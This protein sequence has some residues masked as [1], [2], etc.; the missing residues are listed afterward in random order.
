MREK[1]ELRFNA[2]TA[3]LRPALLAIAAFAACSIAA[4]AR[5]RG[6]SMVRHEAPR[7]LAQATQA[8]AAI[9]HVKILRWHTRLPVAAPGLP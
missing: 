4:A 8:L 6:A 3:Q 2:R 7:R 5:S 1:I 9:P